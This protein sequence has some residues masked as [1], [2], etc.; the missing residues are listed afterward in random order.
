MYFI[1]FF[2]SLILFLI[3]LL[4]VFIL[5]TNLL[6][7]LLCLELIIIACALNFIYISKT[8][9]NPD[10][11][12]FA[13]LLFAVSAAETAIGLGLFIKVYQLNFLVESTNIISFKK[14]RY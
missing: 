9:S 4:G 10:G 2:T 14:F 12:I 5:Q 13:L 6:V 3:G 1:L 7:I 8:L 11:Q